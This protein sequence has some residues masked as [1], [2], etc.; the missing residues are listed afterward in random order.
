LQGGFLKKI[1]CS[2]LLI[3]EDDYSGIRQYF[4]WNSISQSPPRAARQ[5]TISSDRLSLADA[6]GTTL[7]SF[8]K[9]S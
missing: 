7:L 1:P 6:K 8:A 3:V 9:E 4:F 5:F 2:F